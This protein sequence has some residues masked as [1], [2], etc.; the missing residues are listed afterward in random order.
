MHY[1]YGCVQVCVLLRDL[2]SRTA[3]SLEHV[4]YGQRECS[5][6]ANLRVQHTLL[7]KGEN[8][9]NAWYVPW[10]MSI[11]QIALVSYRTYYTEIRFSL[12][13]LRLRDTLRSSTRCGYEKARLNTCLTWQ[14][15]QAV[16]ALA[17]HAVFPQ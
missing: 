7:Q 16:S 2:Y 3:H 17:S 9:F 12:A 13:L 8:P 1:L 15:R 4:I 5:C 11:I 6:Y 14:T 10:L